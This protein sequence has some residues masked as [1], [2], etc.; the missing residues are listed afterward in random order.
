MA[1]TLSNISSTRAG[2]DLSRSTRELERTMGRISSGL[3]INRA[4]D[5]AAGLAVA[6]GLSARSGSLAV[7]RRN[8]SDGI[9][10][11]ETADGATG[12]VSNIVKRMRE[13]AVQASSETLSDTERGYLN[14]EY[15]ELAAEI[16]R[17]ASSTEFNGVVLTDGSTTQL[18]V[19]VG[20]DNTANDRI[21]MTMGDVRT[22]VLGIDTAT[23]DL[24][25]ATGAQAAIDTF[26][27]ALDTI[28]GY[29][30]DYG[31]AQN[32]LE[33]ALSYSE[34]YETNLRAAE[35][36]IRDA[37]FAFETAQMAKQQIIQQ[38]GVSVLAQANVMNQ[39]ILSLV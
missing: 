18:S 24:S 29:R 26:D 16:E 25:T 8:T 21:T 35:S 3:R 13:L 22:T 17:V 30:G 11:T 38:A 7:A 32:R 10:F 5:D 12:E 19:Q 1:L 31:A 34:T 39:G 37:D 27:T 9:S 14:D 4:G 23:V 2:F 6:E 20:I 33:S 15:E 28:A 36:T